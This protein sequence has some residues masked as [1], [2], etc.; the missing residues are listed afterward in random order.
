MCRG[1]N[2]AGAGIVRGSTGRVT[3]AVAPW[4]E[5]DGGRRGREAQLDARIRAWVA[6]RVR[7]ESEEDDLERASM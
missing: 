5:A 7:C 2:A 4:Y 3:L 1:A 6:T